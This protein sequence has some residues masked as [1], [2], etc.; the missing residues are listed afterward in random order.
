MRIRVFHSLRLLTLSTGLLCSIA[1]A[2]GEERDTPASQPAADTP[3]TTLSQKQFAERVATTLQQAEFLSFEVK[4]TAGQYNG[5]IQ[6]EMAPQRLRTQMQLGDKLAAA[7]VLKN[8]VMQEFRPEWQYNERITIPRAKL[9]YPAITENGSDMALLSAPAD[10]LVGSY[11]QSW[12]GQKSYFAVF[13]KRRLEEGQVRPDDK[14]NGRTCRVV[15]YEQKAEDGYIRQDVFYFDE[16]TFLPAKWDTLEA[17]KGGEPKITRARVFTNMAL[18]R[19]P[20]EEHWS[21][22][23]PSQSKESPAAAVGE[24][25]PAT[26]P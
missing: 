19:R 26:K 6:C 10:C 20:K 5:Q 21:F 14:I 4:A 11:I 23:F 15:C 2:R 22:E 17:D 16:V 13:F 25:L 3:R 7:F 8:G 24:A 12:L 9:E 1:V 18:G